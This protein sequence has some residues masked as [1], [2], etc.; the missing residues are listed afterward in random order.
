MMKKQLTKA[1]KKDLKGKGNFKFINKKRSVIKMAIRAAAALREREAKVAATK[2]GLGNF[3]SLAQKEALIKKQKS[4]NK[5]RQIKGEIKRKKIVKEFLKSQSLES[6]AK[7]VGISTVQASRYLNSVESAKS[8]AEAFEKAG[9]GKEEIAR[10]AKDEFLNYNKEKVIRS[11]GEGIN[12]R[13]VEE[14]RDGR[15]AFNSLQF[16]A[17]Y[18]EADA[19]TIA[20]A[21]AGEVSSD[22]AMLAI[23]NLIQKLDEK[24]LRIVKESVEALLEKNLKIV[25]T[26]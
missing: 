12:A 25:T 20:T 15:L 18:I 2:K 16:A 13:E 23:K 14:M 22:I 3:K 5:G 21:G 1:K 26:A 11:Y 9:L 4:G 6:A 19:N 7:S 24:Q 10:I 8:L 17:K